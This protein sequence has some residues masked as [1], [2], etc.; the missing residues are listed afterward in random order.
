MRVEPVENRFE[1]RHGDAAVIAARHFDVLNVD[2]KIPGRFHHP[3]RLFD[4]Y[5]RIGVAVNHELGNVRDF[6]HAGGL[7]AA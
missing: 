2:S 3:A 1:V 5:C 7:A 6:R 4:G